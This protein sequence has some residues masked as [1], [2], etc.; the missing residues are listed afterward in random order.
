MS[1]E[2]CFFRHGRSV[3]NAQKRFQGQADVALDELGK[4]Q[5]RAVAR[6]CQE[7]A[8]VA[9]I[10]SDLSRCADVA[11]AVSEVTALE[12][13]F[14]QRLRERDV[15][16]WSGLTQPEVSSQF[17]NDF[18]AW[19]GGNE[20]VRPGGGETMSDLLHRVDDFMQS[21]IAS[22]HQ[23]TVVAVSHGAWIKAL[24]RWITGPDIPS[25]AIG[26]PS[27]ASLTVVH[28]EDG[29]ARLEAFNDRGHLLEVED[30]DR[31]APSPRIY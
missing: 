3:W 16:S 17:P 1:I 19:I 20:D 30:V 25:G 4:R 13:K 31:E 12:V 6:R 18:Q 15:G 26:V 28:I 8:P 10:S 22:D 2:L 11:K 5:A 29:K 14:D 21:I 27:Q 7:M 9:L 24:V 23:G